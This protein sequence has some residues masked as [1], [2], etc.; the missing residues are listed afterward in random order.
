MGLMDQGQFDL[1]FK[2]IGLIVLIGVVLFLITWS[3]IVQCKQVSPY[4]CQ[5][6]D[7]IMGGPR[8][9]IVYGETGLGDPQ[10]LRL[11]LQDSRYVAAGAVDMLAIERVSMGNLKK[12]DLVIVEHAKKLSAEHLQ[13]FEDYVVKNGG[14]LVWVADAGTERY[15]DELEGLTDQNTGKVVYNNVWARVKDDPDNP[16]NY[17]V[18]SFDEFLGVRYID[19]YC[20][21][22]DCV[23]G[24]FIVG[25]I[26]SEPTGE[27][28]LIFGTAPILNFKINKGRGFSVVKQIA[29]SP[30]SNIVLTLNFGGN[31]KGKTQDLGKII[32]IIAT[33]N[34]GAPGAERVA[35]YAYPPEWF[36]ADNGYFYFVKNLYY[37]MLGR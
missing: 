31:I 11:Y 16:A 35:Y 32:P 28:P 1:A 15:P 22:K 14:R 30:N 7:M 27:H 20:N 10:Q 8:V 19:N 25:T 29:N 3:G 18:V 37:G 33:S 24:N 2:A 36:Y 6:Y 26:E 21:Q 12:Y 34:I 17:I 9:L 5:A 23:D 13:M 4:W